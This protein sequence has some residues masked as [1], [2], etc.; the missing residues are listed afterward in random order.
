MRCLCEDGDVVGNEKRMRKERNG[1]EKW[2]RMK[3]KEKIRKQKAMTSGNLS[4]IVVLVDYEIL[5][6]SLCVCT[7]CGA[8]V[9]YS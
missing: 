6:E 5:M 1:Q 7:K 9:R 4:C 2:T 3:R 8:F